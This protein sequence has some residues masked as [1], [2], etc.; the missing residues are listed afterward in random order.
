MS[1]MQALRRSRCLDHWPGLL[2]RRR[3]TRACLR[4]APGVLIL[5]TED[6]QLLLAG[7]AFKNMRE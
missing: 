4:I 3:G 2:L 6:A 7:S 1:G 5:A